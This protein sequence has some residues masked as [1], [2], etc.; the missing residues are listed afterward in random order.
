RGRKK[1]R[2]RYK[3]KKLKT[4][5]IKMRYI[6]ITGGAGNVGSG[7]AGLLVKDQNNFVVVVDDLSTGSIEKLPPKSVTNWKFI[8]ADANRFD[9]IAPV[10]LHYSFEYVFHYAAVVG[11]QRTLHMP[12]AVLEDIDGIKN[13]LS[14]SKGTSVKSVFFS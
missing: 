4:Q 13:I 1:K 5:Q 8:R 6:L 7:L 12:I 14:L 2:S 3:N 11:V 9:E 10:M